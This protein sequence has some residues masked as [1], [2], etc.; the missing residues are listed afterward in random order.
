MTRMFCIV[1]LLL[2]CT[3]AYAEYRG[4][5]HDEPQTHAMLFR[6]SD[7]IRVTLEKHPED[8]MARIENSAHIR[9]SVKINIANVRKI[10]LMDYVS[11]SIPSLATSDRYPGGYLGQFQLDP[12]LTFY[13]VTASFKQI[14]FIHWHGLSHKEMV[15]LVK[16]QTTQGKNFYTIAH[17][18][19]FDTTSSDPLEGA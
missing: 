3:S 1:V 18:Q 2:V 14:R 11:A 7:C 5:W 4:N 17:I 13:E 19:V 9:L 12:N 10:E 16:V 15:I 8:E 6:K